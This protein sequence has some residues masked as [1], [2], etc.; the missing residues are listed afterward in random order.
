M[1][2]YMLL[3]NVAENAVEQDAALRGVGFFF[4]EPHVAKE[5]YAFVMQYLEAVGMIGDLGNGL[6]LNFFAQ[7]EHGDYELTTFAF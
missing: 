5:V 6:Q 2:K 4:A 7:N 1:D 3:M